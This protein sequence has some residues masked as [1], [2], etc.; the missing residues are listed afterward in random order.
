MPGGMCEFRQSAKAQDKSRQYER[1][2]LFDEIDSENENE[3][4][5]DANREEPDDSW[6]CDEHTET[7]QGK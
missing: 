5:D 2:Y 3:S 4:S 7:T 6:A 1:A